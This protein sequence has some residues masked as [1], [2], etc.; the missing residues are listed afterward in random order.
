MQSRVQD[1]ALSDIG[2]RF[3]AEIISKYDIV[4]AK[5]PCNDDVSDIPSYDVHAILPKIIVEIME[6]TVE[7]NGAFCAHFQFQLEES[8]NVKI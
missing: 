3:V 8:L 5:E 2:A 4:H 7:Y 1:D 6:R